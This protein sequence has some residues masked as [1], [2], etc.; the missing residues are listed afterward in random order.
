MLMQMQMQI[1]CQEIFRM[2]SALLRANERNSA[3]ALMHYRKMWMVGTSLAIERGD[4]DAE[5]AREQTDVA[6]LDADAHRLAENVGPGLRHRC[7]F[8][9]H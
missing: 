4:A 3:G 7:G 8:L 2:L 1:R 9:G 6:L 5:I